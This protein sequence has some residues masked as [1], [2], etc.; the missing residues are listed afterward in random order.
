[1][2]TTTLQSNGSRP[3]GQAVAFLQA[4]R[5]PHWIKNC[6]V[7]APLLF[8]S[9][10]LEP[11]AIVQGLLA[12][13]VFCL[14]A[15]GVYLINDVRDI[16]QD[17]AHPLKRNRPVASGR[18]SKVAAID[19]GIVLMIL[20]V[21][22]A[23]VIGA[24]WPSSVFGGYGL[25]VWAGGYVVLNVLYSWW[26]KYHLI[27][28]VI[29]ISFGFVLR[30]MAGAAAINV[31]VSPWLV[32]CTFTL[33]LFIALTK[34][35]AE[36]E[37]AEEMQAGESR[38]VN[39]AY[40]HVDLNV[41]IAISAGMAIIT[42]ALYCLAPHTVAVT[43]GSPNLIWTIPLVVYGVFRFNR[44]TR[45]YPDDPVSVLVRDRAMYVV[46]VLYVVLV[47]LVIYLG[48]DL[49]ILLDVNSPVPAG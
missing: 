27:I 25:L 18:L 34:R 44:L 1:M 42:Y 3:G 5:V 17:R 10:F 45:L 9:R 39:A 38:R 6:F 7:L 37:S 41:M 15:S 26:L 33:C 30:A 47:G 49:K 23:W 24:R 28:D 35:R 8:S 31:L 11:L 43:V 16:E 29:V 21:V 14:L 22:L 48:P 46:L 2:N 19:G 20:G 40:D 12:T 36:V 32:V 13:L 4:I